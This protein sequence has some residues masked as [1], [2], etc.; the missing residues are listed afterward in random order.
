MLGAVFAGALK[1]GKAK[2]RRMRNKPKG[3]KKKRPAFLGGK[4]GQPLGGRSKRRR[5]LKPKEESI[6]RIRREQRRT[7]SARKPRT[8]K[9][10][11]KPVR[12][13]SDKLPIGGKNP[14]RTP[15]DR[16]PVEFHRDPKRTPGKPRPTD[17]IRTKRRRT[18]EK[19]RPTDLRRTPGKPR[20][21]EPSRT[22][23]VSKELPSKVP[24]VQ[25]RRRSKRKGPSYTT[26]SLNV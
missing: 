17:P 18:P 25:K 9:P 20:V 6:A 23:R 22:E 10:A 26:S 2:R 14:R 1:A 13:P 24:S 15:I 5:R 19:T 11:P 21:Q 4:E 16:L 7:S 3:P 8:T 12:L